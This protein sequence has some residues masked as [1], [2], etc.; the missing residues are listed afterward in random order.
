MGPRP[1]G[2][3]TDQPVKTTSLYDEYDEDDEQALLTS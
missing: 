2:A 3:T 1:P